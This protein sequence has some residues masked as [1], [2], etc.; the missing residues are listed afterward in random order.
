[1][2]WLKK[3][4]TDPSSPTSEF[5]AGS[6]S[7]KSGGRGCGVGVGK[8]GIVGLGCST[9]GNTTVGVGDSV[10][11]LGSEHAKEARMRAKI[12]KN[13]DRRLEPR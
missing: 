4:V 7:I 5:G 13:S 10:A 2:G 1:M 6:L 8:G 11:T 9:V 3:I 12:N